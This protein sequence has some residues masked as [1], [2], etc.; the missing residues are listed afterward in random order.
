VA[1]SNQVTVPPQDRVGPHQ[2]PQTVQAG[3][4]ELVQQRGQPGPIGWVEPDPLPAELAVQ[5]RELVAQREDLRVLVPVAAR[6]QPQQRERVGD[7][8]V[9]QS[10]QH[11]T[12]SS[13]NH[14]R[15]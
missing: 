15:R 13:R 1:A 3:S 14:Q 4:G 2:Q 11:E 12:A 6:Q 8:Q 10:Q 9:R 5:Y 7:A